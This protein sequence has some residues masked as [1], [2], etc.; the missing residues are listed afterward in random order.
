MS[1]P[2]AGQSIADRY[3]LA[4]EIGVG[5]MATVWKAEHKALRKA[6]AIKLLHHELSSDPQF[7][8][9]FEQEARLAAQ[10]DHPNCVVTT[11]FGRTDEGT[12]YLVM[13]LIGGVPLSE[14]CGEGK[15]L[16][17]PQAIE[18]ARQ[19]LRGLAKAHD[20]GIVHRDLKPTNVMV[21]RHPGGRD[22]VKIIDFG[23]AKMFAG[24]TLGPRVQTEAG[25]VFGTADFLAP[26]RLSGGE[27][28][29]RSD[30]YSVAVLLYE[31]VTGTRPFAGEDPITI[32][33][34][35]LT[36]EP[37]PP[38]RVSPDLP[39]PLNDIIVRGLAKRPEDR[40]ATARDMLGALDPLAPKKLGPEVVPVTAVPPPRVTA[41]TKA[42]PSQPIPTRDVPQWRRMVLVALIPLFLTVG[43]LALVFAGRT[44]DVELAPYLAG[45][46]VDF[47]RDVESMD[48]KPEILPDKAGPPVKK[49]KRSSGGGGGGGGGGHF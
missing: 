18:I 47:R 48:G 44:D 28:D 30:L 4:E 12:L 2:R 49:R 42:L 9:R 6:V 31:M 40:Y 37:L 15:R 8:A 38:V 21:Q 32:V 26:E 13:E 41:A 14:L 43:T 35:A 17:V 22:H 19:I 23:I 5:G 34:R 45:F 36:E 7:V 11:D 16:P 29:P 27:A 24:T 1:G 39:L 33:R 10:L 3:E 46:F 20:A 25:L